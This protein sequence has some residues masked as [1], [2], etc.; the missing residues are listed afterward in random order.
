MTDKRRKSTVHIGFRQLAKDAPFFIFKCDYDD[1]RSLSGNKHVIWELCTCS[2]TEELPSRKAIGGSD[3]VKVK[4]TIELQHGS[5]WGLRKVL[6]NGRKVHESYQFIDNGSEHII[7]LNDQHRF[8][9]RILAT[10]HSFRYEAAIDGAAIRE[11]GLA[12]SQSLLMS[13]ERSLFSMGA[14]VGEGEEIPFITGGDEI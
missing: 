8:V 10:A 6:L 12:E 4:H 9:I 11:P 2:Q 13:E 5:L 7:D 14:G 3:E 1:P